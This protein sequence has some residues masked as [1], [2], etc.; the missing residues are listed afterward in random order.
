[1]RDDLGRTPVLI[2]CA[3]RNTKL[4]RLFLAYGGDI[5]SV[6]KAKRT[7]LHF[8]ASNS[9][10]TDIIQFVLEQGVG[11]ECRDT[12]GFS[13][14]HRAASGRNFVGCKT[15][16][17]LGAMVNT[18]VG[19]TGYTP[20]YLVISN[21]VPSTDPF[22]KPGY[23]TTSVQTLQ[24][25]LEY[26]AE[27]DESILRKA[28]DHH[29]SIRKILVAH[30]TKMEYLN[31]KVNECNRKIIENKDCYREYYRIC[32]QEID[33]MENTKFYK[34]VSISDLFRCK[35]VIFG[36]AR[37]EELVK[38]LARDDYENKFPMYFASLKERFNN[39]VE[40]QKLRD[41]RATILS[42]VLRFNDRFHP[43]IQM[44]L[45]FLNDKDLTF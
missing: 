29:E 18:K 23:V 32:S 44:I 7:A 14:L 40:K 19:Q 33:S 20:M 25:L 41:N 5:G 10:N 8:A 37:N 4:V 43:V 22:F 17:K 3:R 45:D 34:D 15:L 1:M 39:V 42:D 6:D 12:A 16:L 38:A 28:E 31:S 30:V 35:R 2:A 21:T 27:V 26:G 11:L 24:V 36:Y 9:Y 13:A